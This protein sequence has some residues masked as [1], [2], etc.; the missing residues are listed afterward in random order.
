MVLK[1]GLLGYPLSH[2][3]SAS[4]FKNM[5]TQKNIEGAYELISMS[6]LDNV[7]EHISSKN[8]QGFNVT[9][10]FKKTIIPYLDEID[11]TASII[12]SVNTVKINMQNKWIGYN[13]DCIG[14]E[15]SMQD[16]KPYSK[17]KALIFGNGGASAAVQ[18]VLRKLHIPFT[19]VS[20]NDIKNAITYDE[21]T[22]AIFNT[23]NV[24]IQTTPVGMY[25]DIEQ[26]LH[27]P[28]EYVTPHHIAFD[29]IYNPEKTKFLRFCEAE[30]ASI[31]N[32]MEMLIKQAEAAYN[33]FIAK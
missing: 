3:Y 21:L 9:I 25:P 17:L 6:S 16:F 29:L 14:I 32:G 8:L 24:L 1:L 4:L 19:L 26:T 11:P 22:E 28:Y 18:F 2:S 15:S 20:R 33:I 31:K 27:L 30:G 7:K 12:G 13:T 10:P 5:F 23:H